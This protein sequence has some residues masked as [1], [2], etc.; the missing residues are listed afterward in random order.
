MEIGRFL[1]SNLV[2]HMQNLQN[3]DLLFPKNKFR[4]VE[5]TVLQNINYVREKGETTYMLNNKGIVK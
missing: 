5:K 3:A 2:I 1:E 4:N